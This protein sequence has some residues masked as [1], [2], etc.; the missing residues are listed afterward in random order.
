MF[1]NKNIDWKN[2]VVKKSILEILSPD[3]E[4]SN[5]NQVKMFMLVKTKLFT[6]KS[7]VLLSSETVCTE[8]F[9]IKLLMSF[10]PNF[11]IEKWNIQLLIFIIQNFS[12]KELNLITHQSKNLRTKRLLLREFKTNKIHNL[13]P[14]FIWILS[15]FSKYWSFKRAFI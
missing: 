4:G 7:K 15:T 12:L 8:K 13:K 6:P 9:L 11:P 14:D 1:N 3:K 2:S 5:G 10:Q